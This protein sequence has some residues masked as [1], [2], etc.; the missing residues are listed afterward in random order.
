LWQ[1]GAAKYTAFAGTV[2]APISGEVWLDNR[3]G[4]MLLILSG[5]G[6]EYELDYQAWSMK[7]DLLRSIG[8]LKMTDRAGYLYVR[9]PLM[10]E[11]DHI[12]VSAEPKG[13]SRFPT[14]PEKI[15]IVLRQ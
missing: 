11:P 4:E 15:R 1:P 14:G 5:V 2:G 6:P 9:D 7:E 12:I 8:L 3:S 13:G 10:G